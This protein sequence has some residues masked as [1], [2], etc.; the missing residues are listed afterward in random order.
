MLMARAKFP[1]PAR[2]K[3]EPAKPA[4]EEP[5]PAPVV[6]PPPP[7][8]REVTLPKHEAGMAQGSNSPRAMHNARYDGM[9]T[10]ERLEAMEREALG[11][12]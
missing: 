3:E 4:A 2:A 7:K 6:K 11:N 1:P 8:T 5:P 9:S 10:A 12:A